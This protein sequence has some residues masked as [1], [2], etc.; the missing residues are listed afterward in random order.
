[1]FTEIEYSV[2][3]ESFDGELRVREELLR[4]T[5]WEDAV[6]AVNILAAE[7]SASDRGFVFIM[8]TPE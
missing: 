7:R 5:V 8:K 4:T 6:T 1:M 2:M 3:R